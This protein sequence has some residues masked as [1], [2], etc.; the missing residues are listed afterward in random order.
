MINV[1]GEDTVCDQCTWRGYSVR[2]MYLERTQC[3]I[4]VLGEDTVCE[5][6]TW[7]GHSV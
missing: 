7:R 1:L 2:S 3:V 5:Q 4:N 6:C